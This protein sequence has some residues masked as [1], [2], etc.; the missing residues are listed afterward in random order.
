LHFGLSDLDEATALLP[1]SA[2]ELTWDTE[3]LSH[4]RT[5]PDDSLV[6]QERLQVEAEARTRFLYQVAVWKKEG[7]AV[8]V[9]ASKEGEE[10]RIRE[11]LDDDT[12]L[13][14]LKPLFLRGPRCARVSCCHRD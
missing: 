5:Y 8:A 10:Q 1:D 6:A 12:S 4:H 13:K 14:K 11:I 2:A 9:V 3:S 7:Y